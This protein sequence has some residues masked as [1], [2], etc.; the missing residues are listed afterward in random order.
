MSW[1]AI[2]GFNMELGNAYS[3]TFQKAGLDLTNPDDVIKGMQNPDLVAQ[4]NE[5][6]IKRGVPIALANILGAKA[7]GAFVAPLASSAKQIGLGL[8][9]QMGVEP[10]FEG[11][12]ELGA[13]IWSG[14][15]IVVP[16][17]VNE[18][19]GG[20]FGTASNLSLK[21]AKALSLIHI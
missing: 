20:Q 1:Q 17:I 11:V 13:Q 7:A 15:G 2:T 8:V 6:G 18:M 12:G 21:V 5:L 10:V 3:S 19:I 14:E 9:S 16:E 4:A